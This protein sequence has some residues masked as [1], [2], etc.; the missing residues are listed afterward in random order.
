MLMSMVAGGAF[1][2]TSKKTSEICAL[3]TEDSLRIVYALDRNHQIAGEDLDMVIAL[4]KRHNHPIKGIMSEDEEIISKAQKG[5]NWL[6]YISYQHGTFWLT[7]IVRR[8]DEF[9]GRL[10]MRLN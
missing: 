3:S 10:D 9:V 6:S 1:S 4:L 8:K 7:Y 2:Q 5:D